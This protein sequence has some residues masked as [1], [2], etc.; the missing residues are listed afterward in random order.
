MGTKM[1]WEDRSLFIN[2]QEKLLLTAGAL[3]AETFV[4][5]LNWKLKGSRKNK[6]L[7]LCIL[8]YPISEEDHT[9]LDGKS[10]SVI[11]LL[12]FC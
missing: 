9:L 3:G 5:D 7:L 6:L 2:G 10:L 12:V 11:F 8:G 4:S 1:F